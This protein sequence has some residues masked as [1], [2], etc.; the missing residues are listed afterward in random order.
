MIQHQSQNT[1]CLSKA[2]STKSTKFFFQVDIT[3]TVNHVF[4]KDSFQANWVYA[5]LP[6]HFSHLTAYLM[7]FLKAPARL[8]S[9]NSFYA[10]LFGHIS[11]TPNQAEH[12]ILLSSHTN[13]TKQYQHITH[14]QSSVLFTLLQTMASLSKHLNHMLYHSF[15]CLPKLHPLLIF[16]K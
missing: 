2:T 1:L 15:H 5:S 10:V 16:L 8:H 9:A 13:P 12:H 6:G 7:L 3:K 14:F 4:L 11:D